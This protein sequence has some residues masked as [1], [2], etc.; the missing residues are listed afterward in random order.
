MYQY[1]DK[2]LLTLRPR[3]AHDR[4]LCSYF[5][6][7]RDT[8]ASSHLMIEWMIF[9]IPGN[10]MDDAPMQRNYPR[11]KWRARSLAARRLLTRSLR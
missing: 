5:R 9:A 7:K 4:C 6:L 10:E 8:F 3:L 11:R 1:P 2:G